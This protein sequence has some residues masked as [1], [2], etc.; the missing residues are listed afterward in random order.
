[1][2]LALGAV[3]LTSGCVAVVAAGAGAGAVAYVRG[4]LHSQIGH[5]YE[6]VCSAASRA[7]GQLEFHMI[8][9]QKDALIDVITA[10]TGEDKKVVIR[11]KSEGPNVTS[12][13]IRVGLVGNEDTSRAI[14]NQITRNL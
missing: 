13:S 1:M 9:Q 3:A 6:R 12:V 10:R 2:A 11:V 4:E 14:L 5:D 8:S 7:V